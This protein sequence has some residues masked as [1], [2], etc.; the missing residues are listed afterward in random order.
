MCENERRS[1][2]V[3]LVVGRVEMCL[4]TDLSQLERFYLLVQVSIRLSYFG[5]PEIARKILRT[6][7]V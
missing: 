4:V 2:A 1:V 7:I 5:K 6:S 3:V